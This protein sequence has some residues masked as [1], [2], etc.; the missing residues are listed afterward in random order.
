MDKLDSPVGSRQGRGTGLR[1]PGNLAGLGCAAHGDGVD[2]SGI[3]VGVA[4]V[5][6][7]KQQAHMAFKTTS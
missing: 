3:A 1:V 5:L 6:V 7:P 2:G 4:V